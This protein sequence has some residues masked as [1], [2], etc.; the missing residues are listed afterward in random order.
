MYVD[1][2]EQTFNGG[3][4]DMNQS[5]S[6]SIDITQ[7][8]NSWATSIAD[9]LQTSLPTQREHRGIRGRAPTASLASQP[10]EFEASLTWEV[11][12]AISDY[13]SGS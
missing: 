3:L 13:V 11:Q 8:P 4:G 6:F 1:N 12:Q 7:F 9:R 10:M 2:T 5:Q